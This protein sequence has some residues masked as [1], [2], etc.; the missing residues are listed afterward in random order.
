MSK[1]RFSLTDRDGR[2]NASSFKGEYINRRLYQ[3]EGDEK[4]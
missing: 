1:S 2:S 4:V 3:E